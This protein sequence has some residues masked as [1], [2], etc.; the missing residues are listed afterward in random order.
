M[1]VG[2]TKSYAKCLITWRPLFRAIGVINAAQSPL[3]ETDRSGD[4]IVVRKKKI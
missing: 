3:S 1:I 4:K 2:A